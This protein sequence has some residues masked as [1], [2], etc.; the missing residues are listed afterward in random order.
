MTEGS[1]VLIFESSGTSFSVI[2]NLSSMGT[3]DLKQTSVVFLIAREV[4]FANTLVI[5]G[6][7]SDLTV[8]YYAREDVSVNDNEEK[9]AVL[10]SRDSES[11]GIICRAFSWTGMTSH[12]SELYTSGSTSVEARC[13]CQLSLYGSILTDSAL[14]FPK[15][16]HIAFLL[17]ECQ[18]LQQSHHGLWR[19]FNN[20]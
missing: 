2:V 15:G 8:V 14:T 16:Y 3:S 5:L 10:T 19:I 11:D 6:R 7:R 17:E 12:S 13:R 20:E 18:I 9:R 1:F 4:V